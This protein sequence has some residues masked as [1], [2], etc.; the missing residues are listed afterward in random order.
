MYKLNTFRSYK[1]DTVSP[2]SSLTLYTYSSSITQNLLIGEK[3]VSSPTS[4]AP[5]IR[6]KER[7]DAEGAGSLW[8]V[9]MKEHI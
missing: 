1:V 4:V 6:G 3:V 2:Y 5:T 9:G 8:W 7:S